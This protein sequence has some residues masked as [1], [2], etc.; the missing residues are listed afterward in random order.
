MAQNQRD[1]RSYLLR[2]WQVRDQGGLA[3]VQTCQ[4]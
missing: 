4:L 1:N 3:N 2:L